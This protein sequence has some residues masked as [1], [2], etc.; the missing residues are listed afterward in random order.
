MT[1]CNETKAVR[2]GPPRL[3]AAAAALA[4]FAAAVAA[5]PASTDAHS[6]GARLAQLK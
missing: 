1:T 6:S 4:L 2:R 3:P 5:A